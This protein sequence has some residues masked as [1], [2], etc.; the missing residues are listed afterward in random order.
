MTTDLPEEPS[1]DEP[2][3]WLHDR[4]MAALTPRLEELR[5]KAAAEAEGCQG[6]R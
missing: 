4:I 1:A 6:E 2:P 5:R 3:E